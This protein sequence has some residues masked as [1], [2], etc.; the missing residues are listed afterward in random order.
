MSLRLQLNEN[1][2]APSTKILREVGFD[3]TIL[4]NGGIL[5]R[6]LLYEIGNGTL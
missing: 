5:S 3:M 2:Q 1:F 6:P 4:D